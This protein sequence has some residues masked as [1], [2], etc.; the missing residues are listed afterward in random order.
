M[1]ITIDDLQAEYNIGPLGQ[2][3]ID[4][5]QHEGAVSIES[6]ANE[7]QIPLPPGYEEEQES[8][9]PMGPQIAAPA[10]PA[11]GGS[12]P[13]PDPTPNAF[14]RGFQFGDEG[15]RERWSGLLGGLSRTGIT[16]GNAIHGAAVEIEMKNAERRANSLQDLSSK[17]TNAIMDNWK[18]MSGRD[19]LS[20]QDFLA[21]IKTAQ[22]RSDLETIGG[23]IR[24]AGKAAV[25][26]IGQTTFGL[27][28]LVN[29]EFAAEGRREYQEFLNYDESSLAA[30]MGTVFGEGAKALSLAKFGPGGMAATYGGQGAG[31][32]R[33]DV[34]DL[35][36][37]GAEISGQDEAVGAIATGA[38]EAASGFI[39]AKLFGALGDRLKRLIPAV[40][41]QGTLATRAVV[42]RAIKEVAGASRVVLGEGA[43]EAATQAITNFIAQQTF[44]PN[45][46]IGEGV[47][48]AGIT[49]AL[50]AP[51]G[52]GGAR[53]GI[54]PQLLE[55][56]QP[57][58]R[59]PEV[60]R[61]VAQQL[62]QLDAEGVP[63]QMGDV[64]AMIEEAE[65]LLASESEAGAPITSEESS[66]AEG[67]GALGS[68][69]SSDVID[70]K[71][72]SQAKETPAS[73][74]KPTPSNK[75]SETDPISDVSA[76][77]E[78][79]KNQ[80]IFTRESTTGQIE[81]LAQPEVGATFK[82]KTGKATVTKV[83]D[84]TVSYE[85]DIGDAVTM[86][87]E[88][89]S[90]PV[91]AEP[92]QQSET[93]SAAVESIA[94]IAGRPEIVQPKTKDQQ[95]ALAVL[96][97]MGIEAALTRGGKYDGV[98]QDIG[99]KPVVFINENLE[100]DGLRQAVSHEISRALEIDK[101][102]V[103]ESGVLKS[104]QDRYLARIEAAVKAGRISQDYL[105]DFKADPQQQQRAGA[106]LLIGEVFKSPTAFR[107]LSGQQPTLVQKMVDAFVGIKQKFT[108][109]S[110]VIDRVIGAIDA[111]IA[112][113]PEIS[114]LQSDLDT[115]SR[116]SRENPLT[117]GL[118][119]RAFNEAVAKGK[120]EGERFSV[121]AFD[122]ANLKAVND[123]LGDA[124]GDSYLQEVMEGI[125]EATRG[126]TDVRR[127]DAFHYGGDEFAVIAWGASKKDADQIL[128][129]AEKNVG[130]DEV[131]PGVSRFLVGNVAEHSPGSDTDV[132]S[133]AT[134]G[135]KARKIRIKKSL[136]EATTR[137][138]ADAKVSENIGDKAAR[139][140]EYIQEMRAQGVTPEQFA[141]ILDIPVNEVKGFLPIKPGL[142]TL[143]ADLDQALKD[144]PKVQGRPRLANIGQGEGA[145][146]FLDVVDQHMENM[147]I[148]TRQTV[149]GWTQE[150]NQIYQDTARRGE[151]DAAM[152]AGTAFQT[153]GQTMA[154]FRLYNDSAKRAL[155]D[156]SAANLA[157]AAELASGY[158][159]GRTETARVMRAGFDRLKTPSERLA[160]FGRVAVTTPP[161]AVATAQKTHKDGGA[162]GNS[163]EL[164]A[165]ITDVRAT[166]Q[167][168]KDDGIDLD[169]LPDALAKSARTL[170]RIVRDAQIIEAKH[171]RSY[172]SAIQEVYRNFVMTAPITFVRNLTG[173]TYAVADILAIK[174]VSAAIDAVWP[175]EAQTSIKG[176]FWGGIAA[177]NPVVFGRGLANAARSMY[178]EQPA[179]DIETQGLDPLKVDRPVAIT[180]AG[181]EAALA[182]IGAPSIG[183]GAGKV[184][185]V[186]GRTV[187]LPQLLNMAVDQIVKTVHAHASV[188]REAYTAGQKKG[189]SGKLLKAYVKA[190]VADMGSDAWSAAIKS[191]DTDRVAFQAEA[192]KIESFVTK[193]RADIPP[194]GLLVPF[195]KTPSN[196]FKESFWTTPGLGAAG[197]LTK[198][199][200]KSWKSRQ[201]FTTRAAQQLVGMAGMAMLW[202]YIGGDDEEEPLI[203]GPDSYSSKHRQ[204]RLGKMQ[205]QPPMTLRI[206]DERVSYRN[207]EPFSTIIGSMVAAG[208]ELKRAQAGK[209]D[210]KETANR[211]FHRLAG[212]YSDMPAIKAVGDLTKMASDPEYYGKN[213]LFT[214]GAG[215]MPNIFKSFQR[216]NDDLVHKRRVIGEEGERAN[217]RTQMWRQMNPH[218][219]HL[220]PPVTT[221]FGT[222]IRKDQYSKQDGW[223]TLLYQRML[224][225]FVERATPKNLEGDLLRMVVKWN[226]KNRSI[227]AQQR[228]F[229]EPGR[230]VQFRSADTVGL[231]R[232]ELNEREWHLFMRL[233]GRAALKSA[234][235][236]DWN[237]ENPTVSDVRL[238]DHIMRQSRTSV[239]KALTAARK[240]K[241]EGRADDYQAIMSHLETRLA[242]IER[243]L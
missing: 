73:T 53:G 60:A 184:V 228:W 19:D 31:G 146:R 193:V 165:W 61:Q 116:E 159:E 142:S 26:S 45:Q 58:T 33:A 214:I 173:G 65:Q 11:P 155:S 4:Q 57:F 122:A 201:E 203:T 109:E 13:P 216:A 46:E 177:A 2:A 221:I 125:R 164:E 135:L 7:Y 27:Q 237:H 198:G 239:R 86:P 161:S 91:P 112:L 236:R 195:I 153:P 103:A 51:F 131:V 205:V 158:R 39:S 180:G 96:D 137:A 52:A 108:G 204:E 15:Q 218:G 117:G 139:V 78:P 99:G 172:W 43:E 92:S 22:Q 77:I 222:P 227:K 194:L 105:D 170:N 55:K 71:E 123:K 40:K 235:D 140:N 174:P 233:S 90:G 21:Q 80:R 81:V 6:L 127:A 94:G 10:P 83:S 230:T 47:V 50:I 145:R 56:I 62:M 132:L 68:S 189:M 49:G 97:K 95:Q 110:K 150:G 162:Q 242:E 66:N 167:K 171:S 17:Q 41:G 220:A 12:Q 100:G 44:N 16:P 154:A 241:L 32:V 138:E 119:R 5:K 232:E 1:P 209:Q 187:R 188:T 121:I 185:G 197:I 231:R 75:V 238:L 163:P 14:D 126:E 147:G 191:G 8:A 70:G 18:R 20:N 106:A 176:T 74:E 168:W 28:G 229:V 156:P 101:L 151:V 243:T 98:T 36:G 76:G 149:A 124:A 225:P 34:S 169:N 186:A 84:Q 120:Q 115:A 202:A 67:P 199:L 93:I 226:E 179:F 37:A 175:G 29:P 25:S 160:E 104:Y 87:R 217:W 72:G 143:K 208:E 136:G 38:V 59:S 152:R 190:Q 157:D 3:P 148:P 24:T 102:P 212:V 206:G 63:I 113:K 30:K 114:R 89:V 223:A 166:I 144:S 240:A 133:E 82:T 118:N 192:G 129:R 42:K 200:K 182:R 183:K 23:R 35:R 79:G 215:F 128:R 134:R 85:T 9:Q 219:D 64:G 111:T 48:Q 54:D 141:D 224:T 178:Y 196:I 213:V 130:R 107:R 234:Q 210:K 88:F 207:I 181:T 211:V 69:L